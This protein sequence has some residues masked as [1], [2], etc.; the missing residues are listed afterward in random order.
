MK[1]RNEDKDMI[2]NSNIQVK[3][4]KLVIIKLEGTNLDW[5]LYSNQF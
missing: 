4:T 1:K 2:V 3:L 5:L